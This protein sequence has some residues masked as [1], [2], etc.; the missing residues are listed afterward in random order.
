MIKEEISYRCSECNNLVDYGDNFCKNCACKLEWSE[1]NLKNNIE[2]KEGQKNKP[3]NTNNEENDKFIR[4]INLLL[5]SLLVCISAYFLGNR[6]N[7][8]DI[9]SKEMLKNGLLDFLIYSFVFMI[10]PIIIRLKNKNQL[11]T[12]Y[13][14]NFEINAVIGVLITT[15][16]ILFTNYSNIGELFNIGYIFGVLLRMSAFSIL[17]YFINKWSFIKN[18]N[19]GKNSTLSIII[20]IILLFILLIIFY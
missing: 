18:S 15:A 12:K 8:Y 3:I 1:I 16:F 5:I 6:F 2:I 9:N 10:Y 13:L 14:E 4:I 11:S 17:Y 7:I 19:N 20:F